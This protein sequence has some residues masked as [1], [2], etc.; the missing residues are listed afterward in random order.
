MNDLISRRGVLARGGLA[1]GMALATTPK[2]QTVAAHAVAEDEPF[3]FCLNTSTIRGQ[4]LSLEEEVEIAARAGYSGIEPWI[5]RIQQFARG[6]GSLSDVRKRIADHGLVVES[7]IGFA[8]WVVE[9]DARRAQGLER[10]K[11]DME[12]V[13][14]IGGFRIAAPP[15]GATRT[16]G[17]DLLKI[18]DRYRAA[19]EIGAELGVVPQLEIWGPSRTLSRLG[20]AAFVAVEAAHPNAC[21]MP[22][23]YHIFRGGSD[24]GG[25]RLLHGDAIH[26]FHMNDY[27][28]APSREQMNDSHRVY[29]GD[30]IAPLDGLFKD[31]RHIGFRGTLSLELFNRGYWE[32]DA[33]SVAQTG[34]RK[35]REQ[36]QMSLT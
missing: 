14:Q 8:N 21:V 3:R 17:M 23:V 26:V 35:M 34:L 25:L 13:K 18:A 2:T 24:L 31:L 4:D 11:L 16:P 32:Q 27:P 5:R 15:A 7:A 33:L 6:G 30:G 19:L 22:D 29:P 12:L 10:L 20:E 1:A 9:D 36:V 28:A